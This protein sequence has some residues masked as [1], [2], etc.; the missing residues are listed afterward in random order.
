MMYL[1]VVSRETNITILMGASNNG[2]GEYK[3]NVSRETML[4]LIV[5]DVSRET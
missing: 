5:F 3:T 4:I 2:V 1:A